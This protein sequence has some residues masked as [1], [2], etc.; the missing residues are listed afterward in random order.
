MKKTLFLL[1]LLVLLGLAFL[2]MN[3]RTSN[4]FKLLTR[5]PEREVP[6]LMYHK[7]NPSWKSGGLGLRVS[8]K[9]FEQQLRYLK[10]HGYTS[11][12][13][14]QLAEH[15]EKGTPLPR[16]PIVLTFDDGYLDNYKYAFPLLKKYQFT[17][18]IFLVSNLV[19]KTNRWDEVLGRPSNPLMDWPQIKEMEK[20]GVE[21][22][23]HTMT[24]PHLG[25][26][27]LKRARKEIVQSKHDLEKKLGHPVST[28]CYPYGSYN[29]RVTKIVSEAGFK[30][31][32]VVELGRNTAST[33]PFQLKRIRVT[34][35]HSLPEFS[36]N[37]VKPYA[38]RTQTNVKKMSNL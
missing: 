14:A 23:S 2:Q 38:V 3:N 37:L 10:D 8:P 11:I 24:H 7:I 26:I 19:G 9:N 5:S 15:Y 29:H 12:T 28:F 17:G 20:Y 36:K 6:I 18:T 33:N 31:A 35:R 16:Y 34:G 13:L 27:P 22:G 4:T 25:A 21:F 30:A 1:S 32:T